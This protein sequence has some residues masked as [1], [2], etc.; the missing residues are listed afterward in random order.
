V[1]DFENQGRIVLKGRVFDS[2]E[3]DAFALQRDYLRAQLCAVLV[4]GR[5]ADLDQLDCPEFYSLHEYHLAHRHLLRATILQQEEGTVSKMTEE[6]V[7]YANLQRLASECTHALQTLQIIEYTR[8]H[9]RVA[10]RDRLK[11]CALPECSFWFVALDKR[12]RFHSEQCRKAASEKHRGPRDRKE[13]QA[14][15]HLNTRKQKSTS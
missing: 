15:Y 13:Q 8:G 6:E 9:R 4:S 1:L 10:L 11:Y 2:R 3:S 12:A 14:E 5:R 7:G